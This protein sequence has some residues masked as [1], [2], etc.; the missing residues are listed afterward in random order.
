MESISRWVWDRISR[1][2]IDVAGA[3]W[4]VHL[5]E[6][7]QTRVLLLQVAPDAAGEVLDQG[8]VLSAQ[9][10]ACHRAA[11]H[12]GG[13]VKATAASLK[14]QQDALIVVGRVVGQVIAEDGDHVDG[15][16]DDRADDDV[17]DTRLAALPSL[18]IA[19][20]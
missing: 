5:V 19:S 11:F 4:H 13:G 6:V 14:I 8:G 20:G 3:V 1:A 7:V 16:Y 12:T 15:V 2:S 18:Q 17:E 10:R 9:E